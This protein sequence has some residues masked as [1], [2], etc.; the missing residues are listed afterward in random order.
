MNKEKLP[1]IKRITVDMNDPSTFPKSN[2]NRELIDATSE[3]DIAKQI[4][5]DD[6]EAQRDV[7]L[8][9]KKNKKNRSV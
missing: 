4:I 8:F 6:L 5:E 2:I 7:L 9:K 1:R 3:E